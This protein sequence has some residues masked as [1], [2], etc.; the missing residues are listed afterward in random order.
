[1]L[2]RTLLFIFLSFHVHAQEYLI[3]QHRNKSKKTKYLP[4]N[5]FYNI[6]TGHQVYRSKIAVFSDSS[7]RIR[8]YVIDTLQWEKFK[9]KINGKW[10]T[11]QRHPLRPDTLVIPTHQIDSLVR[12]RVNHKKIKSFRDLA[13]TGVYGIIL[14][15]PLFITDD[16]VHLRQYLFLE[17]A[18][19]AVSLPVL[20]VD[21]W[22]T[23]YNLRTKW[24]LK[25]VIR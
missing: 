4:L 15:P 21:S 18:I 17:A 24:R 3:L 12:S 14:I 23:T 5:R 13:A 7:L 2:L 9:T 11:G 6:Y 22:R 8:H 19:F 20:I 1:M 16:G 25:G 10:T